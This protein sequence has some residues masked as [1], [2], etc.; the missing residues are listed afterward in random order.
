MANPIGL[1]KI[2][3][4]GYKNSFLK[5]VD[6]VGYNHQY[7]RHSWLAECRA[8]GNEFEVSSDQVKS[9]KS[10]GCNGHKSADV[11]SGGWSHEL[12]KQWIG[13]PLCSS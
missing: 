11:L 4:I 7:R 9:R 13:R 5:V 3:Y 1:N 8:C 6:Y 10:C 2:D 12:A